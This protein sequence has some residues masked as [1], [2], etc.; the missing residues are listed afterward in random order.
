MNYIMFFNYDE[1]VSQ[2]VSLSDEEINV[3]L[4]K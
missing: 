2:L 1:L 3:C 4:K